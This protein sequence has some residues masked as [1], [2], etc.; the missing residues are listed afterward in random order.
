M[1]INI[2]NKIV[3]RKAPPSHVMKTDLYY[4]KFNDLKSKI[5]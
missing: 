5:T 1:L 4:L 3:D 2:L